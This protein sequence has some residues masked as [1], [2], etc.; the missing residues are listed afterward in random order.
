MVDITAAHWWQPSD[1]DKP[2]P[3]IL[4][5][6]DEHGWVLQLD[7]TFQESVVPDATTDGEPIVV[8]FGL[9][10]TFPI[11]VGIT[12]HGLLISL[13]DCQ[14]LEASFPFAGSRGS[15][16]VWPTLLI[17]DV[18]FE[19]ADDFRLASLS[20]RYSNL[21]TWVATSGFS[22]QFGPNLYPAEVKYS[23][24]E[25]I[26]GMLSDGLIIGVKFSASGPSVPAVTNV[27]IVQQSW[28]TVTSTQDLL[29]KDLFRHINN[30]ANFVSLGVGEPLIPLE[31]T[32]M[33]TALDRS[34]A[35]HSVRVRLVSNRQPIVASSRDVPHWDMLFTLP[36]IRF[37]DLVTAWFLRDEALQSLCDLYFGTLRS[38]SM[39]V[40]HRFINMFQ[41]LESYDRRTFKPTPEKIRKHQEQLDRILNAV[42][43]SDQRWLKQ[44]LRH[45]HE[46]AAADRIRRL[47]NKLDAG[48][49]LSNEDITLA[50]SLRNYYTHFDPEVDQRLPLKKDRYRTMHNLAVRL[51]V[52]CELVLLDAIGFP[53]D[54]ARN[55]MQKTRRVER[56]LVT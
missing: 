14:V 52:L 30:L 37:S 18:H 2:L 56:H 31:M 45:S 5:K 7:G 53:K 22:V 48:W 46:P 24:P 11:L 12:S 43:V 3:G 41:A 44:S 33:C 29:Y 50:G 54:E 21:D 35:E 25:S 27:H 20:I 49:L 23:I 51:R 4:L 36:D 9:P 16:K 10:D 13:V 1:P 32:A 19:S 6:D 15:L 40:E 26:E 8:E 28:L 47:A 42:G 38:P 17:Y 39:Y 34:G 55:R